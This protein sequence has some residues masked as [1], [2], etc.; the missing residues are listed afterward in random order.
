M[1]ILPKN[2]PDY[3]GGTEAASEQLQLAQPV[4]QRVARPQ[5]WR[6]PRG[7]IHCCR[8]RSSRWSGGVSGRGWSRWGRI[9]VYPADP[10]ES[11]GPA[12]GSNDDFG[13]DRERNATVSAAVAHAVSTGDIWRNCFV[14]T[15]LN[16]T[17]CLNLVPIYIIN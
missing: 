16:Y 12:T 7:S 6:I 4:L 13:A 14:L 17:N 1:E 11:V 2:L 5:F 8:Q 15:N 3:L 9:R 10:D